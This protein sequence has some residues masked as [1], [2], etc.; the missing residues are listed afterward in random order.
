MGDVD[1]EDNLIDDTIP[2]SFI[3][4]GCGGFSGPHLAST[5]N[6]I[7]RAA[8]M[9]GADCPSFLPVAV[10]DAGICGA[11]A[12]L[13]GQYLASNF[14]LS[15]ADFADA[16]D[17]SA[18]SDSEQ[19]SMDDSEQAEQHT[20]ASSDDRSGGAQGPARDLLAG[21]AA[22]VS[23]PARQ[24]GERSAVFGGEIQSHVDDRQRGYE[25]EEEAEERARL[26]AVEEA[27]LDLDHVKR[28]IR[29]GHNITGTG[30]ELAELLGIGSLASD[31]DVSDDAVVKTGVD[32][33][34]RS[35]LPVAPRPSPL[36]APC[37]TPLQPP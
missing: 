3:R 23:G 14:N 27:E 31:A 37:Q 2:R 24:P 34:G 1:E 28:L 12:A 15:R 9:R 29:R 20:S 17:S 25:E 13:R 30:A 8:A 11:G 36:T 18:S 6:N 5:S 26:R 16:H 7:S 33:T 21:S 22:G 10:P 32:K 4:A 35:R 19:D